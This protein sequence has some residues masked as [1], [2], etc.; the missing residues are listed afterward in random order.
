[1]GM[2]VSALPVALPASGGAPGE[3]GGVPT[4]I[5]AGIRGT[6][7]ALEGRRAY[8]PRRHPLSVRFGPPRQFVRE[9]GR[10]ARADV[11]QRIMSDIAALLC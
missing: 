7:A 5:P 8:V 11:T 4:V 6:F 9:G 3:A 2:T 10:A 1:M